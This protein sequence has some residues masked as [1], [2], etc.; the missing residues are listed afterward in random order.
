MFVWLKMHKNVVS[1]LK[2]ALCSCYLRLLKLT[3]AAQ[4]RTQMKVLSLRECRKSGISDKHCVCNVVWSLE[5]C[6]STVIWSGDIYPC[7]LHTEAI[8]TQLQILRKRL[9]LCKETV[10][11]WQKVRRLFGRTSFTLTRVWGK[12]KAFG[13]WA[14][15]ITER[16]F[17]SDEANYIL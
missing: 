5:V 12:M 9:G 15:W 13:I 7:M 8:Q 16:L 6:L 2:F 4:F 10:P 17:N 3:Y 14:V 11:Y 1:S